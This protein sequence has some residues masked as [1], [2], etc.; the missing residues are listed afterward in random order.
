M[1]RLRCAEGFGRGLQTSNQMM[2]AKMSLAYYNSNASSVDIWGTFRTLWR[3]ANLA[4]FPEGSHFPCAFGHLN[5]YSATYYTYLWSKVIAKEMFGAF[6]QT[7]L[8]DPTPALRYRRAI[9][10]PGGSQPAAQLLRGFLGRDYTS[11]AWETWFYEDSCL[12]AEQS[13]PQLLWRTHN[14]TLVLLVVV[15][16]FAVGCLLRRWQLQRRAASR[17]QQAAQDSRLVEGDAFKELQG[18]APQQ[19]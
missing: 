2:Y 11:S 18:E 4:P 1:E 10:E 14:V 13:E 7:D 19:I 5:G 17:R 15:V 3:R 16:V 12:V 6:N 8:L 9:L